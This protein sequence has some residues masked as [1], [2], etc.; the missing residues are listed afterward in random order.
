M[1]NLFDDMKCLF[2]TFQLLEK[3]FDNFSRRWMDMKLHLRMKEENN[4]Q[5]VTFRSRALKIENIIDSDISNLES[6]VSNENF[7]DWKEMFSGD[8]LSDSVMGLLRALFLSLTLPN[9]LFE[10]SNLLPFIIGKN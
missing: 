9:H 7:S 6:A 10:I 1:V 8:E 3:I 2:I 4:D 5:L